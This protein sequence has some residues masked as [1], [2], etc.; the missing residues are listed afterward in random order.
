[1]GNSIRSRYSSMLTLGAMQPIGLVGVDSEL[2]LLSKEEIQ[3]VTVVIARRV[4]PGC[5]EAYKDWVLTITKAA[6]AYP[7]HLGTSLILPTKS[8]DRWIVLYRWGAAVVEQHG[9]DWL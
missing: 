9:T 1:M 3:P 2:Q 6:R 4:R 7:G 8:D 5:E